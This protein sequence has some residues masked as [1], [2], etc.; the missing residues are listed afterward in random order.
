MAG[1]AVR[2]SSRR[3]QRRLYDDLAWTWRIVSPPGDYVTEA[4]EFRRLIRAYSHI[5]ARTLLDLGCG[6][7]HNDHWL[8]RHFDVTGVDGSCTMLALARRLNPDVT[9]CLGDMRTVRLGRAFD[10]VIIADS[11]AYMLTERDLGRAFATAYAHLR[12]GGVL[13]TYVEQVPSR[14][15]QNAMSVTVRRHGGIEI[16]FIEN[17]YDPDPSDTTFESA[18]VFLIREG[19]RPRVES[20]RHL[21]G[22]F[23]MRTWLRLLR[24]AG[25]VARRVDLPP[26][27]PGGAAVPALVCRRDAPSPRPE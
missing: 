12:P 10:A 20:D 21:S 19:G 18:F 7:G 26:S 14:F 23:P 16:A 13:V 8:R 3:D 2:T 9:Y 6:G 1:A 25:F 22:I 15:E 11:I 24:D 5:H 4:G 27:G 17:R